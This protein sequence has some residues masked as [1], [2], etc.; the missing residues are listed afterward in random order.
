MPRVHP[1]ADPKLAVLRDF[2]L[3]FG[4]VEIGLNEQA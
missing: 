3:L 2:P 1:V 4:A